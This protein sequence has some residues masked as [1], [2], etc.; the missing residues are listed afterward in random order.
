ML[1]TVKY[2]LTDTDG[3]VIG[4]EFVQNGRTMQSKTEEIKRKRKGI[5]FTNAVV[6]VEGF[7]HPKSADKP[8]PE[9]VVGGIGAS[10]FNPTK[11]RVTRVTVKV[12]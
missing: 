10:K 8:I 3:K 4:A 9:K 11:G 2:I 6:D 5:S 12:K 7:I 1:L